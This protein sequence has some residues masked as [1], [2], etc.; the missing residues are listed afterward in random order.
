MLLKAPEDAKSVTMFGRHK[1]IV[2]MK[3]IMRIL[4]G[5]EERL[6]FSLFPSWPPDNLQKTMASSEGGYRKCGA[7]KQTCGLVIGGFGSNH[8]GIY[9][10][11]IDFSICKTDNAY[12]NRV[13]KCRNKWN[14]GTKLCRKHGR[15]SILT[16]L[17]LHVHILSGLGARGVDRNGGD[18]AMCYPWSL[19]KLAQLIFDCY[20]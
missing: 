10:L 12:H 11:N 7:E 3:K 1:H 13:F 20:W 6:V 5:R 18:S 8:Q 16:S 19:Q 17:S 4:M 2:K 14:N 9:F 15:S